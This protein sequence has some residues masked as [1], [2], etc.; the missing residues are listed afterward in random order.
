MI[1]KTNFYLGLLLSLALAACGPE[2]TDKP[3][4]SDE[5]PKET[6]T[7][8][9]VVP[10]DFNADSAYAFVKA[11]ADMGPRVPGSA[12]HKKAVAYYKAQL[13]KYGAKVYIQNGPATSFDGKAWTLSN[14]IG[15]INP[16][17]T[18]RILLSAHFDSRPFCEKETDALLKEKPCPGVNDGASGVG[19]LLEVARILQTKSPNIG[20]DIILFDL[21][22]YGKPFGSPEDETT[23]CL[24]S[25]YWSRTPH[26]QGYRAKY[27]I[28]LDM[29]GAKDA[30]FPK[31][32]FSAFFAGD[33][34]NMVW[35][36]AKTAGYSNYFMDAT[37]G[38]ITD[39]HYYIN[40]IAQIPCI[41]ILH[42][43]MNRGAFFPHHHKNSDDLSTIDKNTLKAVGQTLLEVIY[44]Q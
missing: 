27:G 7:K 26:K 20:V 35:K 9:R 25:Q 39:D 5:K 12:A 32:G 34:L 13:E 15:E 31:E 14:V 28:L 1:Q 23:W 44:N 18:E 42:Y 29:V 16:S 2:T 11:Q 22:D 6:V 10:P 43:D 36:S 38:E 40:K 4:T 17:A 33:V 37:Y 21:E 19:V 8:P 41:D 30:Q 24:G 3:A